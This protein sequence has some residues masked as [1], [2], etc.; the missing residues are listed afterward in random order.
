MVLAAAPPPTVVGHHAATTSGHPLRR[1]THKKGRTWQREWRAF[2][3]VR[4]EM[5]EK[6][7]VEMKENG[8]TALIYLSPNRFGYPGTDPVPEPNRSTSNQ[9]AQRASF[10]PWGPIPLYFIFCIPHN[11]AAPPFLHSFFCPF[12]FHFAYSFMHFYFQLLITFYFT[13]SYIY[14]VLFF[15]LIILIL[16][17]LNY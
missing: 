9:Q 10:S 11:T 3:W 2:F 6:L 7:C 17:I 4:K 12:L 13:A 1:K 15:Y 14:L 16:G 8:L 5:R